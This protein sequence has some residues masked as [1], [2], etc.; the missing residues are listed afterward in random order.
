MFRYTLGDWTLVFDT[1]YRVVKDATALVVLNEDN[2]SIVVASLIAADLC[3]ENIF[4]GMT[5]TYVV[6]E[7][8][9]KFLS[10]NTFH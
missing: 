4:Y 1:E 2:E 7:Q 3:I 5:Y 8:L 10:K 9:V 6:E